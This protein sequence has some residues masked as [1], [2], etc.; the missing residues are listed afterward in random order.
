MSSKVTAS[1]ASLPVETL[2]EILLC[3][4]PYPSVGLEASPL[5]PSSGVSRL[6]R[7]L[8]VPELYRRLWVR[9]CNAHD[10]CTDD[11]VPDFVAPY[12]EDICCYLP[13]LPAL[14]YLSVET[15]RLFNLSIGSS[16][17]VK[18]D[19]LDLHGLAVVLRRIPNVTILCAKEESRHWI[20]AVLTEGTRHLSMRSVFMRHSR[21]DVV[22]L[23]PN[24]ESLY[25][26]K[27]DWKET[28][29]TP[30]VL[31]LPSL[32]SLAIV[33]HDLGSWQTLRALVLGARQDQLLVLEVGFDYTKNWE[34][35]M[36]STF[37]HCITVINDA[38]GQINLNLCHGTPSLVFM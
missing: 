15:P 34:P 8:A 24:L 32:H 19:N 22:N 14:Q 13:E 28:S 37:L 26:D 10:A 25:L 21:E 5:V 17:D 27:I 7:L 3:I 18:W 33:V 30:T 6:W 11:P 38:T 23:A 1:I 20:P 29:K 4:D 9:P 12:L 31:R 2:R 35:G 16:S 36:K